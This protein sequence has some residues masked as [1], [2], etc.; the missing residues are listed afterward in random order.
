MKLFKRL[1]CI[2]LILNIVLYIACILSACYSIYKNGSQLQ[3]FDIM[4]LYG[5]KA[6]LQGA[7]VASVYYS[8]SPGLWVLLAAAVM[9]G[10]DFALNKKNNKISKSG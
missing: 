2:S 9:R 7:A 5:A 10:I 3:L 6:Y 8:C 1:S 4:T